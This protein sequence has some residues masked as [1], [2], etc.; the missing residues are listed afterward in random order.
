MPWS[1]NHSPD[2][3]ERFRAYKFKP[4]SSVGSVAVTSGIKTDSILF[5]V[6]VMLSAQYLDH[7]MGYVR[8]DSCFVRVRKK[9]E[10]DKVNQTQHIGLVPIEA[11]SRH[12][13]QP[14]FCHALQPELRDFFGEPE[15]QTTSEQ[16][17]IRTYSCSGAISSTNK[18]MHLS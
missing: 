12:Q 14:I 2:Q 17:P 10:G 4:G 16:P 1:F 8:S 13:V 6:D 9:L 18:P 3:H 7:I 15:V 5:F 11:G